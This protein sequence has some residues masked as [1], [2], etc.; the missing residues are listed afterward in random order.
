MANNRG[1]QFENKMKQDWIATMPGS[2]IDRIYDTTN[3][4]A[5]ISNISDFIAYKYPNIYYLECKSK[6][7]NTFPLSNFTQYDKLVS[8]VGIEGVRAGV[9]L[10]F[11]DHDKVVYVPVSTFTKLKEDGKKSFNVKMLDASDYDY[12]ILPSTKKRIFLD[13]DYSVL[14]QLKDG[15]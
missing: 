5:A 12:V 9:V 14:T 15:Q 4:F 10:W 11:I 7:G 1:K 2:T 13:S 3:G 6:E 8:K